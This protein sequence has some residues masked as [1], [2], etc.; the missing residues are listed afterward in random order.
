M[1]DMV[2][3]FCCPIKIHI[4]SF[5]MVWIIKDDTAETIFMLKVKSSQTGSQHAYVVDPGR[6]DCEMLVTLAFQ[7]SIF[8]VFPWGG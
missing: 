8:T 6:L 1:K 7:N 5:S 3:V 2:S 4:R